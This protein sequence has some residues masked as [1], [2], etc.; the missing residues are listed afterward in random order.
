MDFDTTVLIMLTEL[1]FKF[2]ADDTMLAIAQL[3]FSRICNFA[4]AKKISVC[5]HYKV[6]SLNSKIEVI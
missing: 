2:I 5:N 4:Y 6:I 1:Y 3:T